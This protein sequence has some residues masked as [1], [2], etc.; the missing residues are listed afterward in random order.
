MW[1]LNVQPVVELWAAVCGPGGFDII[2]T[3]VEISHCEKPFI[4][5]VVSSAQNY[6]YCILWVH[7]LCRRRHFP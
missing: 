4:Q 3:P 6:L 1:A 5:R 2:L 7:K